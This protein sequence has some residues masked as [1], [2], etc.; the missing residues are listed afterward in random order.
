MAAVVS[1]AWERVFTHHHRQM[2]LWATQGGRNE[3]PPC[4]LLDAGDAAPKQR[5]TAPDS[6]RQPPT[7]PNSAKQPL[8]TQAKPL[9]SLSAL[10]ARHER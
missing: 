9:V 7:A 2:G 10:A 4:R 1:S 3:A 8:S 5:R 6:P